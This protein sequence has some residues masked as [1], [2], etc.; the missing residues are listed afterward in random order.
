MQKSHA[1]LICNLAMLCAFSVLSH[2]HKKDTANDLTALTTVKDID[3]SVYKTVIK[4]VLFKEL[5]IRSL[6]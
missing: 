3:G 5:A 4:N 2:S 1:I 6:H